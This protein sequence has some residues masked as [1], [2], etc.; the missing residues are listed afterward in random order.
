MA[1][2][3]RR[4]TEYEYLDSFRESDFPL[5]KRLWIGFWKKLYSLMSMVTYLTICFGFIILVC[6]TIKALACGLFFTSTI[7]GIVL[8]YASIYINKH[9]PK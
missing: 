1:K 7:L 3:K 5:A 8:I 4:E 2:A 6:A 9:N